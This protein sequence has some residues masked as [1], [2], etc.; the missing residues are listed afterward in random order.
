MHSYLLLLW[1]HRLI[2]SCPSDFLKKRKFP[3]YKYS[4]KKSN[5]SPN[6]RK[7]YLYNAQNE[8]AIRVKKY[9]EINRM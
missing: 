4:K 2:L 3:W 9:A 1:V 7:T 6:E 5:E 8:K